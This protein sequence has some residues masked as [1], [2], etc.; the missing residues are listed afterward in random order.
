ML[1][2]D[3]AALVLGY[4]QYSLR[5]KNIGSFIFPCIGNAGGRLTQN[6]SS[7]EK[8]LLPM[9]RIKRRR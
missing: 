6:G 9:Q 1:T 2:Q 5:E 4:Y 8:G 3:C 7:S